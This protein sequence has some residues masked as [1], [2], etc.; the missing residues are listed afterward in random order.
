SKIALTTV[1]TRSWETSPTPPLWCSR[2]ARV[3][4]APESAAV[5]DCCAVL[6]ADSS[7]VLVISVLAQDRDVVVVDQ[8][9]CRPAVEVVFGHALLGEASH[10][11]G[12]P[13]L[14]HGEELFQAHALVVARVVA[15]VEFVAPAEFAADGV[16]DQLHQLDPFHGVVAVRTA[17]VLVEV[18]A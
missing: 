1:A 10:G 16:P 11:I 12:L 13:R 6:I 17:H 4:E 3:A 18:G 14:L 5:G 2:K 9:R 15:L 7:P 8:V